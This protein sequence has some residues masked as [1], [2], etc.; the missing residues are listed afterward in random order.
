MA[1]VCR[2]LMETMFEGE[3]ITAW[4]SD[5]R[6]GWGFGKKVVKLAIVGDRFGVKW[7]VDLAAPYWAK[8]ARH[9]TSDQTEDAWTWIRQ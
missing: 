4:W 3:E 9:F 7:L 6:F 8:E 1:M 5:L 2:L